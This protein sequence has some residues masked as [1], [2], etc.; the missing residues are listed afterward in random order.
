M[1]RPFTYVEKQRNSA[2]LPGLAP[3]AR[4]F[5]FLGRNRLMCAARCAAKISSW[6]ICRNP[7][8]AGTAAGAGGSSSSVSVEISNVGIGTGTAGARSGTAG[9]SAGTFMPHGMAGEVDELDELPPLLY[10]G[11]TGSALAFALAVA[12]GLSSMARGAGD[13][14][15]GTRSRGFGGSMPASR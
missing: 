8:R 12:L 13:S 4:P 15:S 7:G 1:K 6:A 10:H 11:E 3:H 14:S 2:E 9:A 5:L